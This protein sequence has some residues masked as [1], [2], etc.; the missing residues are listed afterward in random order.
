MNTMT[1]RELLALL[2]AAAVPCRTA[3]PNNADRPD[4]ISYWLLEF[5]EKAQYGFTEEALE[6]AY[7]L[8]AAIEAAGV[9]AQWRTVYLAAQRL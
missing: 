7:E 9:P 6:A 4:Y 8:R 1:R 5:D 2:T 3:Q